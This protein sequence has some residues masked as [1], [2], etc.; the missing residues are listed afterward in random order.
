[1]SKKIYLANP[2]GFSKQQKALLL[3]PI[4]KKLKSLGA[5]VWEPFERN[6]QLD[7][8]KPDWAYKIAQADL[9]D[10]KN[11]TLGEITC[12]TDTFFS[13]ARRNYNFYFSRC[14]ALR[15]LLMPPIC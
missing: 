14:R 8:S 9:N 3:P 15:F 7:C 5:E 13:S 4:V 10:V 2:Y 1:M 6:K 11:R 12:R